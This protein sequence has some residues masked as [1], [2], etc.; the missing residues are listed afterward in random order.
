MNPIDN[1]LPPV[2]KLLDY[3]IALTVAGAIIGVT[4]LLYIAKHFD[5]TGG[6]LSISLL[7]VVTFIATTVFC[8]L[9]N[10]PNDEITSSV[11]GGL[12]ASFGAVIAFWLGKSRD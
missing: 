10:V 3:P 5:S 8:L 1:H 6:V 11:V 12:T 7:V 4:V 9:F 2:P